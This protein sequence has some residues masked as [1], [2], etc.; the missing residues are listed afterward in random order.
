MRAPARRPVAQTP[1]VRSCHAR[2]TAHASYLPGPRR[3]GRAA[4]VTRTRMIMPRPPGPSAAGPGLGGLWR[5]PT[6]LRAGAAPG[7][8]AALWCAGPPG[9]CGIT[10]G[11]PSAA[12]ARSLASHTPPGPLRR[13]GRARAAGVAV[14]TQP[15]GVRAHQDPAGSRRAARWR[16][17]AC[18]WH[19]MNRVGPCRGGARA[20]CARLPVITQP[21]GGRAR[22]QPAGSRRAASRRL[23]SCLR[24]HL[25]RTG[26][27]GDGVA[28][29]CAGLPVIT[30]PFGGRARQQPAGSWRAADRA[31]PLTEICVGFRVVGA[32]ARDTVRCPGTL[33]G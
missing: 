23:C 28:A 21:I 10:A 29:S 20:P 25:H 18:L 3:P 2:Q 7:D 15:F 16:Q 33:Y 27:S 13:R 14:I 12:A 8:H 32:R 30:Q 6:G 1:K 5:H 19:H 31:G 9:S 22:Q 4:T 17:P 26:P 24:C 11:R